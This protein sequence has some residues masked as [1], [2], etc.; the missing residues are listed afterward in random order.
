MLFSMTCGFAS[1]CARTGATSVPNSPVALL[2]PPCDGGALNA[3]AHVDNSRV[4][5]ACLEEFEIPSYAAWKAGFPRPTITGW[6]N[7]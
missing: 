2:G 7:R 1:A 4:E 5:T 6:R 3:I